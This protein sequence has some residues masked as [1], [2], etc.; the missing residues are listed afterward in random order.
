MSAM[1]TLRD[2]DDFPMVL[3]DFDHFKEI[4]DTYGHLA[5]DATLRTVISIIRALLPPDAIL[6]RFGGDEFMLQ[7]GRMDPEVSR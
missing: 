3:I 2:E 5:G 1:E 6:G 7:P 4:N